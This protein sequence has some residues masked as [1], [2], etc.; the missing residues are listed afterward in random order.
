M[1]VPSVVY[2]L[3]S[4]RMVL[5]HPGDILPEDEHTKLVS[6]LKALEQA[7][8]KT[9]Y[10][11]YLSESDLEQLDLMWYDVDRLLREL[12]TWDDEEETN[13]D[14]SDRNDEESGEEEGSKKKDEKAE[15][16]VW[17]GFIPKRHAFKHLAF[18]IRLLGL[19]VFQN[20]SSMELNH[21]RAVKD[22]TMNDNGRG[23]VEERI[24]EDDGRLAMC[25]SA[26]RVAD[27]ACDDYD[28]NE[29]DE[30]E[31][32]GHQAVDPFLAPN[33]NK[34][35]PSLARVVAEDSPLMTIG[36][37]CR[38]DG[39]HHCL[40][41]FHRLLCGRVADHFRLWNPPGDLGDERLYTWRTNPENVPAAANI[42]ANHIR[43]HSSCRFTVP[44][45]ESPTGKPFNFRVRASPRFQ[46]T[47]RKVFDFVTL[48]TEDSED[49]VYAQVL[50]LFT[51]RVR[52]ENS[53][54][55]KLVT[56][57][58]GAFVR[59]LDVCDNLDRLEAS[60]EEKRLIRKTT[61]QLI[62]GKEFAL[63]YKKQYGYDVVPVATIAQK[64][65]VVPDY[66]W[67][68]NH[69][70]RGNTLNS[71]EALSKWMSWG[72]LPITRA[73]VVVQ[74]LSHRHHFGVL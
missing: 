15:A 73:Q 70:R 33:A 23:C 59:Y 24:I 68:T 54:R 36:P 42:P 7:I 5:G 32:D 47:Q 8:D 71:P 40:N 28:H 35:A 65:Y 52:D 22:P 27:S 64:L 18:W 31:D 29:A 66:G 19:P 39:F 4:Y 30:E 44:K 45:R 26:L 46:Y 60:H 1:S 74:D 25:R 55:G 53:R 16:G 63:K 50:M 6:A 58:E 10:S 72:W 2:L 57:Y 21:K 3:A 51:A 20:T 11:P 56:G 69:V 12:Y 62:T 49:P 38:S 61:R 67:A 14:N 48:K 37:P 9:Y 41:L 17:D 43:V 34:N 13:S